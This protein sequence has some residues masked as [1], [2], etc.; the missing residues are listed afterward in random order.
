MNAKTA[1]AAAWTFLFLFISFNALAEN[2]VE[3]G[4]PVRVIA[5]E[6]VARG[7]MSF[8][9]LSSIDGPLTKLA[10]DRDPPTGRARAD[11]LVRRSGRWNVISSASLV[12]DLA[13]AVP[14]DERAAVLVRFEQTPGIYA[15]VDAERIGDRVVLHL[16]RNVRIEPLPDGEADAELFASEAIPLTRE[17]A[18]LRGVPMSNGLLCVGDACATISS[19]ADVIMLRP[20]DH[21][22]VVRAEGGAYELRVFAPGTSPLRAV[23][24]AATVVRS[25]A[26][27]AVTLPEGVAWSGVVLDIAS[28]GAIQRVTGPSL[29]PLPSSTDVRVTAEKG[30]VVRPLIGPEKTRH[31]DA[32]ASL[33]VFP[34]DTSEES[35]KITIAAA[36]LENGVFSLPEIGFGRYVLKLFSPE[37]T[38]E[39]VT[40]SLTPG[41]P[42]DVLFARGPVIRGRVVRR[43]GGSPDDPIV[44]EIVRQTPVA[45]QL[46]AVADW[47]RNANADV[48][49][50]FRIMLTV[51]GPYRLRA[52]WGTAQ[53]EID[54]DVKDLK[55]DVNLGE[56][57]LDAG[58]VLRGTL[59]GCIDGELTMVPL[60]DLT[61]PMTVPFFDFR[62]I[63][64]AADGKFVA[65][66][67]GRGEWIIGARCGG[68]ATVVAPS[69][70][71]V[72]ESGIVFLD[73][74]TASGGR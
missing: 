8:D 68:V 26:W 20:N 66:G 45:D 9:V 41:V 10:F 56:I 28:D 63:P 21:T 17:G 7:W 58:A 61:K 37:A 34:A 35:S 2:T 22:R 13:V 33:Y 49:G 47:M 57:S 69:T 46:S 39:P 25:G 59:P 40:V 73:L 15:W 70:V 60:P 52:R 27:S 51:P 11:V 24:V 3:I 74:R 65:E 71:L 50:S 23:T 29:L 44:V 12:S 31:G 14:R 6:V 18:V 1:S 53:G 67:L 19:S 43:A 32:E 4:E 38:G 54:F 48:D 5:T 42:A 36:K 30:V 64:V 62:R 55:K 72:P 16:M